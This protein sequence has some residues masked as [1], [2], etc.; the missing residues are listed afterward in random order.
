MIE[1]NFIPKFAVFFALLI[2]IVKICS[3]LRYYVLGQDNVIIERKRM[4][5]GSN[6]NELSQVP[7]PLEMKHR[8]EY[9]PYSFA[10]NKDEISKLDNEMAQLDKVGYIT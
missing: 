6:P 3:Y 7:S 1:R 10:E 4:R 5:Y 9:Q 8:T 2:K